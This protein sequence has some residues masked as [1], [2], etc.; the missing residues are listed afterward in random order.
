MQSGNGTVTHGCWQPVP[1]EPSAAIWPYIR[2]A[3]IVSSNTYLIRS[4]N[5]TLVIDP[6]GLQSQADEIAAV[7]AKDATPCVLVLLTH[8]HADHFRPLMDHPYFRDRT[9]VA[10]AVQESGA[11]ALAAADP[12]VTQSALLE[13]EIT[14]TKT[15]LPLFSESVTGRGGMMTAACGPAGTIHLATTVRTAKDG[16]HFTEQVLYS[17]DSCPVVLYH[18]PGHSPDSICIRIG[19]LLF[20][21]DLLFAAGPGVAGMAGWNREE[22]IRS[23][24]RVLEILK[25]GIVTQCMPGH[26]YILS[27]DDAIRTLSGVKRDAVALEGIEELNLSRAKETAVYAEGLMDE[28]EEIFTVITARL[29]FVSHVLDELEESGEAGTVEKLID[30]GKIDDLMNDFH[31][32]SEEHRAGTKGTMQL[33][34]KAGQIVGKLDRMFSQQE[35]A[36]VLDPEYV[37]RA[38]RLLLDY[39]IVLRG[40]RQPRMLKNVTI[41]PFVAGFVASLDQSGNEDL[42]GSADDPVEFTRSLI[43]KIARRP[44]F[45]KVTCECAGEVNG[46]QAEIDSTVLGDLIRTILED[47]AGCGSGEIAVKIASASGGLSIT[48]APGS[49]G[50][51]EPGEVR[52]EFLRSECARAGGNLRWMA[53]P[54]GIRIELQPLP[55][56]GMP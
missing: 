48:I 33:A 26:G 34:L 56:S 10:L 50:I 35:L 36:L 8:A 55:F 9:R 13:K 23:I 46:W 11:R 12:L 42:M 53:S 2:K 38:G 6:G 47:F 45:R 37:R 15:T 27:C 4:G 43:R 3:D 49:A 32:F 41:G 1:G 22:L 20:I 40:F 16:T 17:D 18:T 7:L 52:K 28:V 14:P 54:P 51:P 5:V 24:D 39:T 31:R 30:A 21:G 44:V 29:L 25:E 19:S